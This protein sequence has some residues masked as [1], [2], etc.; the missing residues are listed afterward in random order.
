MIQYSQVVI[1]K[2]I[3]EGRAVICLSNSKK[4]LYAFG[5]LWYYGKDSSDVD[6]YEF[7][8]WLSFKKGFGKKVLEAGINLAD[9]TY[10]NSKLIAILESNNKKAQAIIQEAGGVL[11][12]YKDSEYIRKQD[13][14]PA[15]MK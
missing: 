4:Q 12:G 3:Y 2:A 7:G 10:P 9:E 15:F 11:Y 8:S 1:L 13:G 14:V 5:Q 6:V